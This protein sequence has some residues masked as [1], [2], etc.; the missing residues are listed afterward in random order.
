[1]KKYLSIFFVTFLFLTVAVPFASAL[2][3]NVNINRT[4]SSVP[5]APTGQTVST[6]VP[7]TFADLVENKI[8]AEL[9]QPLAPLLVG[10]AVVVFL[11]GVYKFVISDS[12]EEKQE[13]REF[14]IWGIVG[15]FIMLSLWGMISILS[16]TFN[17]DNTSINSV[18]QVSLQP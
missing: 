2:S 11:F 9:L 5:V 6:G 16:N 7:K 13:G 3:I 1:M 10:I 4:N 12:S 17:L 15:L 14:M 18:P 8:I